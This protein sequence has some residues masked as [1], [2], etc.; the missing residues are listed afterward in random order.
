MKKVF[1]HGNDLD[2]GITAI[3]HIDPNDKP[4]IDSPAQFYFTFQDPSGFFEINRCDCTIKLLQNETELDRQ[5]VAQPDSPFASLGSYPLYTRTFEESGTYELELA[6]TPKD[7]AT[8]QPF[9]LHFDVKVEGRGSTV[10]GYHPMM[11]NEHLGHIL[12]FGG[13]LVAA[14]ALLIHGYWKNRKSKVI[15]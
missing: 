14:I 3:L 13:G 4:V 8:F 7:G 6:G 1:A 5:P 2:Q 15:K 9:T 10:S 11:A 12:I